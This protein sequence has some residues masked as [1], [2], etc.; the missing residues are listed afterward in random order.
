MA[1]PKN[2]GGTEVD[3]L[4]TGTVPLG[5]GTVPPNP[6]RYY[7]AYFGIAIRY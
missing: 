3:F 1:I 6:F 2:K 4:G 5:T 7:L